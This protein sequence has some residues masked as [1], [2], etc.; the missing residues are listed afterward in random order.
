MEK[1]LDADAILA[2]LAQLR[3]SLPKTDIPPAPKR[4]RER[5]DELL[6][7]DATVEDF[8]YAAVIDALETAIDEVQAVADAA[9]DRAFEMALDI[10]YKTEE[11][12]RDPEQA[13]LIPHL[14]SMRKAY[15]QS[16]GHPVPTKAETD[17]RRAR[18]KK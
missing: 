4:P 1:K 14:E 11:L 5:P 3:A 13:H 8:E 12:A 16:Y 17:R 7:P 15:V 2:T 9:R 10:Y 6:P 18:K